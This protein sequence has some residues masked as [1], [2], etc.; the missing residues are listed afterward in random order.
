MLRDFLQAKLAR[1][2]IGEMAVVFSLLSAMSIFAAIL[3]GLLLSALGLST[4]MAVAIAALV[5]LSFVVWLWVSL[6]TAGRRA[7][8]DLTST[9]DLTLLQVIVAMV[10]GIHMLFDPATERAKL[11]MTE[12]GFEWLIIAFHIV[13]FTLAW[14]IRARVPAR[15]YMMF[16]LLVARASALTYNWPPNKRVNLSVGA[17]HSQAGYARR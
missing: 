1:Y 6:V 13:Y 4:S 9:A 16:M 17:P 14:A 12:L 2:N 8:R 5:S 15:T 11:H 10:L 3:L 7:S